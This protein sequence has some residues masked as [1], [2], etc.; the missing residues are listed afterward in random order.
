MKKAILELRW[1]SYFNPLLIRE[2]IQTVLRFSSDIVY[3]LV[4]IPFSSGIVLRQHP[5]SAQY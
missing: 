1:L 4:S 2:V 3:F 5:L